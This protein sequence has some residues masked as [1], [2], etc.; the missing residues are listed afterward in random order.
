MRF[1]K[2]LL[3]LLAAAPLCAQQPATPPPSVPAVVDPPA[4]AHLLLQTQGVGSQVYMCAVHGVTAAWQFKAPDAKLLDAAGS[5]I[6]IHYAGPSWKLSDGSE[7]QGV[8]IGSKPSPDAGSI[9]WLL[10]KA[11]VHEGTGKLS[12]VDYIRRIDTQGGVMPTS[13]CDSHHAGAQAHIH[14]TAAYSFYGK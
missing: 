4:G 13:G 8:V 7:V 10:L 3:A 2:L 14:Y 6:G 12:Q 11:S 1:R 5:P 9:P